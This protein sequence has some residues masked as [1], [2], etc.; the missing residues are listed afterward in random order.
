MPFTLLM[1]LHCKGA[2]SK[3]AR[4][5]RPCRRGSTVHPRSSRQRTPE[6]AKVFCHI[7][8]DPT[9]VAVAS[10]SRHSLESYVASP[11]D[12]GA[13]S[14]RQLS[15]PPRRCRLRPGASF[16]RRRRRCLRPIV[17]VR[18]HRHG[19]GTTRP[20]PWSRVNSSPH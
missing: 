5:H 9:M 20:A 10:T 12:D 11:D 14:R 17:L 16:S 15:T 18:R 19:V 8:D 7:P 4:C 6:I 3:W 13:L 2:C 1:P